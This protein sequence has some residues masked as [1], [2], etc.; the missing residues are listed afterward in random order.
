MPACEGEAGRQPNVSPLGSASCTVTQNYHDGHHGVDLS[1]GACGNAV[2][3]THCGVVA[4]AGWSEV[5][6]GNLVVVTQDNYTTYYAHLSQ[7]A[8]AAGD[9]VGRGQ[10]LGK[11]G[12]TG[13]STG[14]HLHYEVRVKGVTQNPAYFLPAGVCCRVACIWCPSAP[15]QCWPW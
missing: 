8:V 14:C 4:F 7:I 12:S 10:T 5:G 2:Q 11:V 15:Q 3:A 6:Y 9:Q 13:H 1:S